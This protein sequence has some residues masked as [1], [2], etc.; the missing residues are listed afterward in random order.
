MSLALK[1]LLGFGT[2]LGTVL[3]LPN[4]VWE[5]YKS[6]VY[7][8]VSTGL[9]TIYAYVH[10]Y[11]PSEMNKRKSREIIESSPVKITNTFKVIEDPQEKEEK[12]RKVKFLNDV[13]SRMK[14]AELSATQRGVR[15]KERKVI[16]G[17][18]MKDHYPELFPD[19]E[20]I[21]INKLEKELKK[22]QNNN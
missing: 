2:G 9:M 5:N 12:R 21:V 4:S 3:V 19:S 15:L 18:A 7:G 16:I 22:S 11:S 20:E 14:K 17:Q 8:P 13:Y 10:Y 1:T 6:Y